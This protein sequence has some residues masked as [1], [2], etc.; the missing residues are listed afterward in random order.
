MSNELVTKNLNK[1]VVPPWVK[2][3]I[4]RV[5]RQ[6]QVINQSD[7]VKMYSLNWIYMYKVTISD[8]IEQT[9]EPPQ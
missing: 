9:E 5:S 7:L 8:S 6:L 4:R 1:V 3:S 2:Y